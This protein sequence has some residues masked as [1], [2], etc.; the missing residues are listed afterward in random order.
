MLERAPG[1]TFHGLRTPMMRRFVAARLAQ[2]RAAPVPAAARSS[3]RP[4]WAWGRRPAEGGIRSRAR[5][6]T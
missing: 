2:S 4:A 1:L 6:V 5:V 3:A